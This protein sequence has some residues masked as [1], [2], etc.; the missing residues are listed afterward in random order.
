[1]RHKQDK[2]P[3]VRLTI[4]PE[5]SSDLV[6]GSARTIRHN[7]AIGKSGGERAAVQTLRDALMT[8][9]I[10]AS[11]WSAVASAPLLTAYACLNVRFVLLLECQRLR[12]LRQ[13]RQG[14]VSL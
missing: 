13:N 1:M 8:P 10:R 11:V 3:G 14:F 12:L 7:S 9:D 6:P 4:T 5:H 2:V